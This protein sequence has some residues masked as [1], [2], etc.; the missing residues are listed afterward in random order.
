MD[1][2]RAACGEERRGRGLDPT[3][4]RSPYNV[5]WWDGRWD[6]DVGGGIWDRNTK[7]WINLSFSRWDN[8]IFSL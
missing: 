8:N 4:Y 5:G 1:Q 7:K 6:R 2:F 3:Y